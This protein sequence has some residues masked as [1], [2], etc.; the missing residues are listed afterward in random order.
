[1]SPMVTLLLLNPGIVES[2]ALGPS[3]VNASSDPEWFV[4]LL[5]ITIAFAAIL[6]RRRTPG[7]PAQRCRSLS[8]WTHVAGSKSIVLIL[9]AWGDDVG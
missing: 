8:L 5:F 1:M 6:S 9:C 7:N 3:H 2:V 4:V